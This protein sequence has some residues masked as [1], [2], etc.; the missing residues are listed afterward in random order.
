M[1]RI[2]VYLS[3]LS[4][5]LS[6]AGGCSNSQSTET[7]KTENESGNIGNLDYP[8]RPITI[9][10]P[11][12]TGGG[13]DQMTRALA[14]ATE[15]VNPGIKFVIQNMPGASGLTGLNY[16][17]Q[18]PEDGYILYEVLT[19]QLVQ[20]ATGETNYKL[21][22]IVPVVQSQAILN[23]LYIK[24]NETRF[25][26]FDGLV[27]YAKEHD[28]E[29][30]VGTTGL[31]SFDSVML[32]AIEKKFG[33]KFK[34]VP[35]NKPAERYAA[36]QGGFID[37]LFEQIGDVK[38]FVDSGEFKPVIVYHNEK[39][40]DFPDVST[41]VEKGIEETTF[42]S[43]GIWAK[44]GTPQEIIDY[45]SEAFKKGMETDE[46]KKF[47]EQQVALPASFQDSEQFKA[48]LMAT[49]EKLQTAVKQ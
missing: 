29:V 48:S 12:G 44:K 19:D 35:F 26:N 2:W 37:V 42:Y 31:N 28:G 34:N 8:K 7:Q 24:G 9:I 32:A 49:Y 46:W 27:N 5:L 13:S 14:A 10:V 21:E 17:M 23:F 45:L 41:T 39:V 25:T 1:K 30:K 11:W 15:K 6:L 16:V 47:N 20:M 33:F 38:Q 43:R 36:L 18:Q 4:L 40:K 3:L 22:D